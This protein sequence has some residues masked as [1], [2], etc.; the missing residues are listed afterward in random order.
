MK[1]L[2]REY[3]KR[4]FFENKDYEIENYVLT[5]KADISIYQHTRG[6]NVI[7]D[8]VEKKAYSRKGYL[9]KVILKDED[10]INYLATTQKEAIL[11]YLDG[12]LSKRYEDQEDEEVEESSY[13]EED[14]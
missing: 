2:T 4:R 7:I 11:D 5:M 9:F 6:K 13:E 8:N 14:E 3:V 10:Y 1:N 12:V